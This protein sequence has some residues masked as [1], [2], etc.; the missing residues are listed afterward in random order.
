MTHPDSIASQDLIALMPVRDLLTVLD[1]AGIDPGSLRDRLAAMQL[2]VDLLDDAD[3]YADPSQVW[4]MF[5]HFGVGLGDEWFGVASRP[6]PPG[7]TELVVARAMHGRTLGE[8]MAGWCAAA[9]LVLPGLQF[10]LKRRLD[11]LHFC[12]AFRDE[13]TEARQILLEVSAIPYHATFRWLANRPL[14][15]RRVRTARSRP[16]RATH[17][18]AVFDCAVQ[19]EGGGIDIVYPREIESLPLV[20]RTLGEWRT[21]IYP[22]FMEDLERRRAQLSGSALTDYV[23]RAL[24]NGVTDQR[25]IAASAGMAEAT[26]RRKLAAERT[27]FRD[28]R[29]GVLAEVADH[30]IDTGVTVERI[31]ERLGYAD[32]RSFRRAFQRLFGVSPA[33]R[34]ARLDAAKGAPTAER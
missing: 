14:P 18:L 28:L 10:S 7:T 33:D 12:M 16:S 3:G 5:S 8:A 13:E 21:G 25:A 20:P 1:A 4:R 11:E 31:A 32:A 30:L 29:D 9:N 22:M 15:V 2:P 23:A 6:V 19:F 27:S 17:F 24:R 26:L 34:R